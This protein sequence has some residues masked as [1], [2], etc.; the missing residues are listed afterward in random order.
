MPLL[1]IGRIKQEKK[2]SKYLECDQWISKAMST[3]E[4]RRSQPHACSSW[5]GEP[6]ELQGRQAIWRGEPS[7]AG[8][9]KQVRMI[10]HTERLPRGPQDETQLGAE[11]EFLP[12]KNGIQLES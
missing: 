9:P 2:L 10:A 3:C 6:R 11:F 12:L 7:P 4:G 5:P 8:G 1:V